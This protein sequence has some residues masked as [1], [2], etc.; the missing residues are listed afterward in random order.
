MYSNNILNLQETTTILNVCTK[1]SGN[2][3]KVPRTCVCMLVRVYTNV[4][5]CEL[6]KVMN[7]RF[8]VYA[9]VHTEAETYFYENH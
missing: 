2:L 7:A 3:L 1:K 4:Y 8:G 9:Y 6:T 5:G